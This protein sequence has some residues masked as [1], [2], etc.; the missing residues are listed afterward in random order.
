MAKSGFGDREDSVHLYS[1]IFSHY[2]AWLC[3]LSAQNPNS[4]WKKKTI[5]LPP[6]QQ[7]KRFKKYAVKE[8]KGEWKLIQISI[9]SVFLFLIT[10]ELEAIESLDQKLLS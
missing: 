7:K 5:I 8:W 3:L 6:K 9:K 2:Q 1:L 4:Y 10:K